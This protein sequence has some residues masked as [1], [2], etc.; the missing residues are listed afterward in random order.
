MSRADGQ[1]AQIRVLCNQV[2]AEISA[3]RY[4][5]ARARLTA[6]AATFDAAWEL[7]STFATLAAETGCFREA[8]GRYAMLLRDHPESRTVETLVAAARVAKE[9][10]E[11][12]AHVA[13]LHDARSL[14]SIRAAQL[15]AL[16]WRNNFTRSSVECNETLRQLYAERLYRRSTEVFARRGAPKKLRVGCL[17]CGQLALSLCKAYGHELIELSAGAGS[18]EVDLLLLMAPDLTTE[19]HLFE[20]VL[21]SPFLSTLRTIPLL[22]LSMA[23]AI[24]SRVH[25]ALSDKGTP[26]PETELIADL[27]LYLTTTGPKGCVVELAAET[28][29]ISHICGLVL[30]EFPDFRQAFTFDDSSEGYSESVVRHNVE[31]IVERRS[32][33][34]REQLN[35]LWEQYPQVSLAILS[36]SDSNSQRLFE[37]SIVPRLSGSGVAL[38]KSSDERITV[39]YPGP[40]AIRLSHWK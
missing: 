18:F 7:E 12:Q 15:L 17:E 30:R 39:L 37:E 1:Q 29:T 9:A 33:D 3:G 34:T 24:A 23:L 16:P 35:S 28:S 14:D 25:E 19:R 10:G 26:M 6:G 21:Q 31:G 27:T 20:Q 36:S 2:E 22:R 4:D 8:L 11:E 40:E 13:L 5:D 38:R 32:G